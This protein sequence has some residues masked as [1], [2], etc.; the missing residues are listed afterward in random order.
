MEFAMNEGLW[1]KGSLHCHS[2]VSDGLLD[3]EDVARF[4]EDR[5]Y[6]FLSITDH[7]KISRVKS[8]NGVYQCGVE[9]SK[10]KCI[11]GEQYHI[12]ALGIEDPTMLR[13]DEAQLFIDRV[14]DEGGLAFI[15]HPYWSNL[16]HDDLVR[17]EGYVGI[18][19]YNTGCDVE[20]AKGYSAIHWDS[21]LSQIKR[22]WGL[23]VDDSHRYVK[24]PL[25]ADGGWV[26]INVKDAN[27]D[28]VLRSIRDG[29]F[30]A[31][32]APKI[33]KFAYAPNVLEVESTPISRLDLIAAN[34]RGRSI[35][36]E[37]VMGLINDWT[38]PG[39]KRLC[40]GIL[41][42]LECINE[43]LKQKVYLETVRGEK[44][45]VERNELGIVRIEVRMNL[46]YPYF[47]VELI[48]S[49]GKHAWVN[50]IFNL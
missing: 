18:E 39:R 34:G 31:S 17:L 40:E 13:I 2:K 23:A 4:Y 9:V 47:R 24:H 22:V 14:N 45:M 11:L 44:F 28:E 32:M 29:R 37:T 21:V 27:P 35:S 50:P 12:V 43:G 5:G 38:D 7:E 6:G 33:V 42:S 48:D 1:L 3:P 49:E 8:F 26:W 15:A 10:G 30:Y 36:I 20:V 16:V 41:S 25:D 19:V 46:N